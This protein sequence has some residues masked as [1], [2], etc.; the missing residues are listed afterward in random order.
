MP[1]T[2]RP[3]ASQMREGYILAGKYRIE[4]EL[5]SGGMGTVVAARH[6]QLE[7]QVAI[8]FLLPAALEMP[9]AVER[10]MR[11]AKAAVR[12]RSEH[13]VR[14]YDVGTLDDGAPYMVM[15][16]LRGVDLCQ[17]LQDHESVSIPD[18]VELILQVLE[19]VADAH[20]VG[21][22][23][24]D[25]KPS[26]LFCVHRQDGLP[27][28]KVLDFGISKVA[29]SSRSQVAMTAPAAVMGS[30]LYMSP[31]QMRSAHNVDTRTDIWAIGI[32]LYEML[33]G[34][35]PFDGVTLSEVCV[36]TAMLP[37]PPIR[38]RCPSLPLELEAVV[39]RCLK[40]DPN[41]R[42]SNVAELAA[43]LLP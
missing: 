27:F 15:E 34:I 33:T 16:Y 11:E 32:I 36:R 37:P 43:A 12:I 7:E 39:L 22:I 20:A 41:E 14:V 6:L 38:D 5:G 26:N 1:E 29:D 23:H 10:F 31:E 18:A 4:R 40:K 21:I 25:L 8:K 28:I 30:P 24:R 35:A 19:A 3:I 2:D 17:W 9:D 42:Y 13:V